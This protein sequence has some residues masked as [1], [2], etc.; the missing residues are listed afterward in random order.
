MA[1][2]DANEL[3]IA[4]DASRRV[5]ALLRAPADARACYV[6]AHG[7]G[8]GMRHAF[9]ES[10]A[11][12]LSARGVATLRYQFPYVEHGGRRPDP[13]PILLAT[14]RAAIA[15]AR[16]VAPD[17]SLLAGG[18]SMGGRMSS[19]V[20]AKGGFDPAPLGLV[21]FGYPLHPP[22]KPDQRRDKHL[23]S[24]TVPMLFLHGARDGFGSPDEMQT[25][26]AGL[27]GASLELIEGGDHSL[28]KPK[29][30]DPEGRSLEHAMDVA[31]RWML[32]RAASVLPPA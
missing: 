21:F 5:S 3:T 24:I 31:A 32:D 9:L 18:K 17:L 23:P 12:R 30:S 6:L 4:V 29:R 27:P 15:A 1:K 25:L 13:Q 19:Q 10:M 8:A 16:R 26:V 14:V 28:L 20:A 2:A 7:A 11:E 22:G